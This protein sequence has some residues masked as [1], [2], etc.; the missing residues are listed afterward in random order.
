MLVAAACCVSFTRQRRVF[1][2]PPN[3]DERMM[4]SSDNNVQCTQARGS[5]EERQNGRQPE[6]ACQPGWCSTPCARRTDFA[7]RA[8]AAVRGVAQ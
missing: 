3:S 4:G 8:V 7:A 5:R 1:F 2:R 6:K